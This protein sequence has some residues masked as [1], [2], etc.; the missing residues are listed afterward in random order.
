MPVDRETLKL[1]AV[2][3]GESLREAAVLVAVLAPLDLFVQG[4]PLTARFL[5]TTIV[6]VAIAFALGILLEV[7]WRWTR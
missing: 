5:V 2:L 3:V 7:K 1:V 6:T 4:R